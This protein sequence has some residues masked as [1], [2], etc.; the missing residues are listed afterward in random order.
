MTRPR[1][2]AAG[3]DDGLVQVSED[4]GGHWRKI[5]RLPGVPANAYITRIRASQHDA[6]TVFLAADNH[7]NGDF[8]PYLLKST[9]RGANWTAISPDLTRDDPATQG[10]GGTPI[11]NEGAGGE[12]YGTIVTI[13]ESPHELEQMVREKVAAGKTGRL[14][15]GFCFPWSQPGPGGLVNDIKIGDYHRPWDLRYDA[16][17][18]PP[19]VPSAGLG[20]TPVCLSNACVN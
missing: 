3:T 18:K 20:R 7:Q 16:T 15:S 6:A 14:V 19:G 4:G 10:V 11:T 5:D 9:D 17:R 13:A 8:A 12:V 2:H 1:G